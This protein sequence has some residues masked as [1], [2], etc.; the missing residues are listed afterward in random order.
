MAEQPFLGVALLSSHEEGDR[1]GS[2]NNASSIFT[3][4]ANRGQLGIQSCG[5][6][7][8]RKPQ[9]TS[10]RKT[11]HLAAWNV[12]TLLDSNDRHE[13]RSTIIARE[14]DGLGIDVAALSE[15][16]ISGSSQFEEV[17]GG[18]V[19]YCT[20]HP[21]GEPRHAGVGFA[22]RSSLVKS[23]RATPLGISPRLMTLQLNLDGGHAATLISCYAP[24][25]AAPQD[26]KEDFY[27]QLNTLIAA[28]PRG[29]KLFVLGDF[30]AR[31]GKDVSLRPKVIGRHGVGN[32]NASGTLL[33]ETCVVHSLVV[34]NRVFQQA[35]K[36][37][38][39]WMHPMFTGT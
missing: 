1:K 21:A 34:T 20:G 18:Y 39:S 8:K 25:L 22:I 27:E 37:K 7:N 2:L 19:F 33:L 35:N 16:R 5:R 30:N 4:L 38:G 12:R 31:V 32:E 29:H 9:P 36:R 11:F 26:E 24:T 14:L 3:L 28:V 10:K 13:R 17:G 23:L 15:T 6:K